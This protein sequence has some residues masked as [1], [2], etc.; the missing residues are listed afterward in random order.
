MIDMNGNEIKLGDF[1]KVYVSVG[2]KAVYRS[3]FKIIGV[4]PNGER[5]EVI[6]TAHRSYVSHVKSCK[7]LRLCEPEELL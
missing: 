4:S 2:S 5:I 6:S 3:T 7:E 1:V